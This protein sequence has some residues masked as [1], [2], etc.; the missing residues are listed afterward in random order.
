[1]WWLKLLH[2]GW[3]LTF[4]GRKHH[5]WQ[6]FKNVPSKICGRQPLKNFKEYDLLKANH[7]L[8][9]FLKAVFHK[10][11]LV[12]FWILW[13]KWLITY[14]VGS[15]KMKFNETFINCLRNA[16]GRML[17]SFHNGHVLPFESSV[18]FSRKNISWACYVKFLILVNPNQAGLFE[19]SFF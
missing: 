4:D 17:C 18:Y 6:V 12:H 8:S 19:G 9:D 16:L 13:L 14:N 1:M 2:V 15:V 11:Y 5:I 7:T 10:F 3:F